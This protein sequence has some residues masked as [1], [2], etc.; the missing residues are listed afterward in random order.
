MLLEIHGIG[1]ASWWNTP[2]MFNHLLFAMIWWEE[3]LRQIMRLHCPAL[4][5]NLSRKNSSGLAAPRIFS[6]LTLQTCSDPPTGNECIY[7]FQQVAFY[8]I[9]LFMF[10]WVTPCLFHSWWVKDLGRGEVGS[11]IL[12]LYVFELHWS[13]LPKHTGAFL[14]FNVEP[15]ELAWFDQFRV[16]GMP[17]WTSMHEWNCMNCHTIWFNLPHKK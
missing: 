4:R 1:P 16:K 13:R 5:V 14:Q 6:Y 12:G 9:Y 3:S 2:V 11:H 17:F 10:L 7:R 8:K 15:G